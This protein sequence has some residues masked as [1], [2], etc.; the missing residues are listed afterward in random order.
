MTENLSGDRLQLIRSYM[1]EQ[2]HDG[3][4]L[5]EEGVHEGA[6][7]EHHSNG[8]RDAVEPPAWYMPEVAGPAP[9]RWSGVAEVLRRTHVLSALS[10]VVLALFVGWLVAHMN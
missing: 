6:A 8:R 9:Y 2:L 5:A 3:P 7:V 10:L 4:D 1:E